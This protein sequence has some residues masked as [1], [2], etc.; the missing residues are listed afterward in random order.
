MATGNTSPLRRIVLLEDFVG[1]GTQMEN[2]IR[3]ICSLPSPIPVLLLPLIICPDG[4][5]M[6]R[7]L[8]VDPSFPHLTYSP[9]IELK[10]ADMITAATPSD[11]SFRSYVADA[12]RNTYGTVVGNDAARP[13]PYDPFGFPSGAGT[14]AT[15]VLYSNA[16][17]NTLPILQHQSDTWNS[18]F[19]R[20][21]RMR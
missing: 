10:R 1:S 2:A 9:V 15:V 14:G 7:R 18:L 4:A 11:G 19:P 13:R 6:G 17:A 16:P 20:S 3:F 21:A 8:S 5:D 12:V